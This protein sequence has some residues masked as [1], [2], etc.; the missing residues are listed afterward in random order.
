MLSEVLSDPPLRQ[1]IVLDNVRIEA[2]G[3]IQAG[4]FRPL[5]QFVDPVRAFPGPHAF[6]IL[7][8]KG[9]FLRNAGNVRVEGFAFT[10]QK[11]DV[12]PVRLTR[13]D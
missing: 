9:L 8:S 13:D 6:G 2:V 10:S 4:D 1:D 5:E 11:P 7:P 3:G 12:R